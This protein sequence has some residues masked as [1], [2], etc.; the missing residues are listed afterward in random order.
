MKLLSID[1]I[2]SGLLEILTDIDAFC[3]KEGL[4]YSLGF[5]TMLGAVRHKGFIPWDDDA[6]LVMSRPDFERFVAGYPKENHRFHCLYNSRKE[7]EWF[8][9]GFAKVHDPS[10][11]KFVGNTTLKSRYGIS[12]DVFPLDRV[13]DDDE[14]CRKMIRKVMHYNRRTYY[15]QRRI[16]HGSPLLLA[17]AYTHS[18]QWWWNKCREAATLFDGVD[19]GRV[20][21]MLGRNPA[22]HNRSLF[23]EIGDIDFLGHKF[24]ALENTNEYLCDLYGPDYMTPPPPAERTG[25]GCKMYRL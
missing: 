23:R 7:H 10:T 20:A 8:V 12:V 14:E 17:E 18:L 6:D 16:P 15:R 13:P 22:V 9:S 21:H 4:R 5:G 3:R 11:S 24:M 19:V 1:E 2:H 25:H